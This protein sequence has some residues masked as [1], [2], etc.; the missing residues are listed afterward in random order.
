MLSPLARE[1]FAITSQV[2]LASR[3]SEMV[4]TPDDWT[5]SY[6]TFHALM[7]STQ[8]G[9]I[10]DGVHVTSTP[11]RKGA[12]LTL[13][14]ASGGDPEEVAHGVTVRDGA[15]GSLLTCATFTDTTLTK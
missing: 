8:H 14:G 15:D 6:V 9:V 13:V 4:R 5:S 12:T 2:V 10:G 1:R 3:I 7:A 11:S